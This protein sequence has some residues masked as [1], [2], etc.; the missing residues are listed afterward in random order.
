MSLSESVLTFRRSQL[1]QGEAWLLAPIYSPADKAMPPDWTPPEASLKKQRRRERTPWTSSLLPQIRLE[2]CL[3]LE[4]PGPPLFLSH[5]W[6][7]PLKR[8]PQPANQSQLLIKCQRRA[9]PWPRAAEVADHQ[10]LTPGLLCTAAV[11]FLAQ[12]W[13][14]LLWC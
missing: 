9:L 11:Q 8:T 3:H 2:C 1:F 4:C 6:P 5:S 14:R 12:I 13:T 10:K 7:L